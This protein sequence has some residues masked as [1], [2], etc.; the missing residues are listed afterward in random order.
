MRRWVDEEGGNGEAGIGIVFLSLSLLA[1]VNETE[2]MMW[3]A[4]GE[5][6][7]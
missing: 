7:S 4:V 1:V 2:M 3:T 6:I 5:T